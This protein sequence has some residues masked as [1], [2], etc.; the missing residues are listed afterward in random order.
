M[1]NSK[2]IN[3]INNPGGTT[4]APAIVPKKAIA[5]ERANVLKTEGINSVDV[6]VY[7]TLHLKMNVIESP[8]GTKTF[9][10]RYT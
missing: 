1:T 7:K 6:C 4:N 9:L 8:K 2:I 10:L 3:G 5:N